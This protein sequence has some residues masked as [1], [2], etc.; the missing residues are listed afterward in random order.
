M[1]NETH[2]ISEAAMVSL[3]TLLDQAESNA[4]RILVGTREELMPVW[5]ILN[6]EDEATIA[7]T[8]W[9]NDDEKIVL[10]AAMQEEMRKMG[11]TAYVVTIEYWF[12]DMPFAY[13]SK[14]DPMNFRPLVMPRND[15][16]RREGIVFQACN[17]AESRIRTCEILRDKKGRCAELKRLDGA[18]DKFEGPMVRNLLLAGEK[19]H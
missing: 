11:A 19:L 12:T 7:G 10:M 2:H 17:K 13:T 1:R 8:P 4:R 9:H 15:P 14:I 16:K 6:E 3:D 18:Q 5:V